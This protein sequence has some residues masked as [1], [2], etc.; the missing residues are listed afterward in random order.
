MTAITGNGAPAG[1]GGDLTRSEGPGR[2]GLGPADVYALGADAE[3][4]ERVWRQSDELRPEAEALLARIGLR[5]G[6]ASGPFPPSGGNGATHTV[7]LWL[8]CMFK[9]GYFS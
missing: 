2:P 4:S 9:P 5:P 8:T 6:R 3:E 1:A 7:L